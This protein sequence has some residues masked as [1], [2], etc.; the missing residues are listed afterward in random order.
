MWHYYSVLETNIRKNNECILF[1]F[2]KPV[3]LALAVSATDN[4]FG[5]INWQTHATDWR[6]VSVQFQFLYP[7]LFALMLRHKNVLYLKMCLCSP[8]SFFWAKADWLVVC[9]CWP[10]TEAVVIFYQPKLDETKMPNT[11]CLPF[12]LLFM[13]IQSLILTKS[14]IVDHKTVASFLYNLYQMRST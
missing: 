1:F 3:Q 7:I 6:C 2:L 8:C 13:K 9:S 12:L 14:S 10:F 4:V 5:Q 11:T